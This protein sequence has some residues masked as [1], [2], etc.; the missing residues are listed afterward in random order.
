MFH[1]IMFS[2]FIVPSTHQDF[3]L[4]LVCLFTKDI[5]QQRQLNLEIEKECVVLLTKKNTFSNQGLLVKRII[6]KKYFQDIL[7]I[8]IVLFSPTIFEVSPRSHMEVFDV[9]LWQ[10]FFLQNHEIDCELFES[11]YRRKFAMCSFVLCFLL[12]LFLV[13]VMILG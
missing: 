2:A 3:G 4:M 8:S 6:L 13:H 5:W 10:S 1:C 11:F 7:Q 12:I 9:P